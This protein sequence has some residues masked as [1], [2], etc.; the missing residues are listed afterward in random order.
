MSIKTAEQ[1][2]PPTWEVFRHRDFSLL[3]WGQ[4]IS[5]SGT[6]MQVVAVSWQ[7][8][9]L[10][11]SPVAL[12]LVGLVQG[13]PR[14][15]FSLVGGVF[16]DVLDRRRLLIVVNG[17]LA[18]T[19]VTLAAEET[20]RVPSTSRAPRP[21]LMRLVLLLAQKAFSQRDIPRPRAWPDPARIGL[22]SL[23]TEA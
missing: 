13:I 4:L 20:G 15:L 3:F 22:L 21:T 12:G 11:H 10:T 1:R 16:A 19:S 23:G 9:L 17:L 7:V 6:Q 18:F 14:L 8:L 5:A 2:R